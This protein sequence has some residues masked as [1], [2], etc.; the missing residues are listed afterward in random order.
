M[1]KIEDQDERVVAQK[2]KIGS[3]GFTILLFGLLLSVLIQQYVFDAP[4]SQYAVEIIFYIIASIYLIVRNM[5]VGNSLFKDNKRGQKIVVINSLICGL[6]IAVISTTSNYIK[7]GALRMGNV[8]NV[9]LIASIT[10]VSG[11][12]TCFIAMEILF[13]ANNKRQKQIEE[14]Y[15]DLDE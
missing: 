11:A 5:M 4:F 3:D 14:Q 15:E 7:Y 2:R 13:L 10:F 9:I 1:K 8:W 6:I 12:I